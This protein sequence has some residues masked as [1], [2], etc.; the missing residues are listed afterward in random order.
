MWYKSEFELPPF[1]V[2]S[3]H[4]LVGR[5]KVGDLHVF[6]IPK[7]LLPSQVFVCPSFEV[8][9]F[10]HPA[11]DGKVTNLN[12]F[13]KGSSKLKWRAGLSFSITCNTSV[14]PLEVM[15]FRNTLYGLLWHFYI[16]HQ[17]GRQQPWVGALTISK[18][19][20][21]GSDEENT[22][23]PVSECLFG[24]KFIRAL[25]QQST[26]VPGNLDV[27]FLAICSRISQVNNG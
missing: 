24:K 23:I 5:I 7:Q 13:C 22:T 12:T 18:E 26:I 14:H 15:P 21:L 25:W 20:A 17:F 4:K 8:R 6:G 3:F 11:P 19:L 2:L 27:P 16:F 10:H 9:I 1:P